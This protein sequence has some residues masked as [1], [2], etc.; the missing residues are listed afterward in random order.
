MATNRECRFL[1]YV[2]HPIICP[3]AHRYTKPRYNCLASFYMHSSEGK[4]RQKRKRERARDGQAERRG[5]ERTPRGGGRR[6]RK[7]RSDWHIVELDAW[8]IWFFNLRGLENTLALTLPARGLFRR[9]RR[10]Y[11][12]NCPCKFQF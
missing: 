8:Q 10:R 2:S 7:T 12:S 6:A 1:K 11:A 5:K 3:S 9:G 4:G